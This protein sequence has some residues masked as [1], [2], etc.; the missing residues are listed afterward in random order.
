[1]THEHRPTTAEWRA[2]LKRLCDATTGGPWYSTSRNEKG[3]L[4]E[5]PEVDFKLFYAAWMGMDRLLAD[6]ERLEKWVCGLNMELEARVAE[7]SSLQSAIE[8][9]EVAVKEEAKP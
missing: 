5:L 7:C 3:D 2:E 4:Y 8:A 9:A 1:M 6:V